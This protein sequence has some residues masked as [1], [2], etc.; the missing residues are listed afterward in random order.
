MWPLLTVLAF[1]LVTFGCRPST[2]LVV[3]P[4]R[5]EVQVA[6][7]P[8]VPPPRS[9]GRL[10]DEVRPRRYRWTLEVDPAG[11]RFRGEVR[12]ALEVVRPTR[13]VVLHASGL[14]FNEI[15]LGFGDRLVTGRATMRRAAGVEGAEASAEE[16]VIESPEVI[17]AGQAELRIAYEGA[18][19][20]TT[21]GL[22][23]SER[24]G[25]RYLFTQLEP[26]DA[27]RVLP[28]FDEPSF[29][30]PFEISVLAPRGQRVFANAKAVR[31]RD[32]GED[33]ESGVP[34]VRTDFE[35][36]RPLPTYLLAFAVGPFDVFDG[37]TEPVPVRMIAPAGLAA[38][39]AYVVAMAS[40]LVQLF[41][42]RFGS[43]YPY[44]KLDLVAVPDFEAGAMENA[45]L[46]LFREELL[47]VDPTS[48]ALERRHA[49]QVMAHELAHQWFG[50]LVTLRW[51]DDLWLN[52]GFASYYESLVAD[53]WRPETRAELEE[54]AQLGRV[55]AL[56]GLDA[57]RRVREPVR[58][59]QDA[60][61]AFDPITYAKGSA[62]LGMIADHLGEGAFQRGVQAYLARHAH[63][64][65][66]SEDLFRAL[67]DEGK[68][69]VGT[70]F[71]SFVEQP[72]VP[73]VRVTASCVDGVGSLRLEQQ[74]YRRLPRSDDGSPWSIPVCV[75]YAPRNGLFAGALEVVETSRACTTLE[76][77]VTTLKLESCA[78]WVLPSDDHRG[79][80]RYALPADAMRT[81]ARAMRGSD[82][83]ARV[84]FLSN[85]WA[86]VEAGEFGLVDLLAILEEFRGD[87]AREVVELVVE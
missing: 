9:D 40:E 3:A 87:R 56:D 43:P 17:T 58:T 62:L 76:G 23:R 46:I 22:Y 41:E 65:A 86:L 68:L 8:A 54:F 82:V 15:E 73:L 60:E 52:E 57:A 18:L 13:A 19:D 71:R 25:K 39:G 78:A 32:A 29:K 1:S 30:V 77:P 31:E 27:R 7:L 48:S 74:R 67:G 14:T 45:G 34:R 28:C 26:A 10:P 47:L 59:V 53:E 12:I 51:W 6:E 80:Y 61:E 70:T 35:E 83:R 11:R 85:A 16:L 79:Y 36:T 69:D 49:L 37:P 72:G 38:R 50:N 4:Q 21:R 75:R 5:A 55:M 24:D 66:S 20:D 44:S 63:G 81:L 2:D 64:G 42:R 84:G 33:P